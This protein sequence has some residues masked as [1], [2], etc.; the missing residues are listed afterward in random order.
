MRISDWSS[1]VCFSDLSCG[2]GGSP[3]STSTA[4]ASPRAS[5]AEL[6]IQCGKR[7][8][9]RIEATGRPVSMIRKRGSEDACM[10]SIIPV[11]A[12]RVAGG[13]DPARYTGPPF[14][15]TGGDA[16]TDLPAAH[17]EA[18][19]LLG[20]AGL[21]AGA[22]ARPRSRRRHLP[23]GHLPALARPGA[24]ERRLRAA[25]PPPHRRP[26]RPEPQPPAALLPVP[27]GDEAL[28]R[29]H[30]RTVLRVAEGTGRRPAGARPAPGRGQLG[31]A[32]AR[33]LGPPPTGRPA[34]PPTTA[35]A[36]RTPTACNATT[37]TRW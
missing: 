4:S 21:R 17:P 26:L 24:V 10:A 28:A 29:Q 18:Q 13:V 25:L 19:R 5:P 20:R 7:P 37:S 11:G 22:A 30:R 3:P 36:A 35:A 23:P 14:L 15:A 8:W 34:A 33:G 12:A 31:I 9:R 1:D 6:R 27:G 16:G 2:G 32:T